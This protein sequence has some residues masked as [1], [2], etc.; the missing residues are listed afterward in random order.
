MHPK[1][2]P[3]NL[4]GTKQFHRTMETESDF[5]TTH[6]YVEDLRSELQGRLSPCR[7]VSRLGLSRA[8]FMKIATKAHDEEEDLVYPMCVRRRGGS[9]LVPTQACEVLGQFACTNCSHERRL[10]L[11]AMDAE[12][13]FPHISVTQRIV[14]SRDSSMR[15]PSMPSACSSRRDSVHPLRNERPDIS[16]Y[17]VPRI[18]SSELQKR[19]MWGNSRGSPSTADLQRPPVNRDVWAGTPKA[20][21]DQQGSVWM[22]SAAVPSRNNPP[23]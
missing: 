23:T 14:D 20:I 7:K 10:L 8:S 13:T 1:R 12:Q 21:Q 16:D 18:T 11:I 3:S 5:K 19:V 2:D 4:G 9:A 17:L 15:M 22:P 6:K